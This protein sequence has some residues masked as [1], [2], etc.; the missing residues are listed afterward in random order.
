M[1]LCDYLYCPE[2]SVLECENCDTPFCLDHGSRGGDRDS[3]GGPV[4]VPSV[5]WKCGGFNA[6]E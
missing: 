1:I 4:A 6:D 5:C 2:P 3:D